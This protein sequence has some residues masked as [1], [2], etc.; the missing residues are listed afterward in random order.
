MAEFKA[1]LKSARI[2]DFFQDSLDFCQTTQERPVEAKRGED[3]PSPNW[4]K[5]LPMLPCRRAL[6]ITEHP[7]WKLYTENDAELL[8]AGADEAL[9][10]FV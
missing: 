6:Q 9:M 2:S 10:Y 8:V 1:L 5:F 7:A 4:R 3:K